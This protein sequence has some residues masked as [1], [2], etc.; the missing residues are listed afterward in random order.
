MRKYL[1]LIM[2]LISV[3]TI[4]S[5]LVQLIM[6]DFVLKIVGAAINETTSHFFSI[7][8]MFMVLFGGLMLHTI[9]S[10]V[11][12][13]VAVQWSALQKLGAFLAVGI[14]ITKGIFSMAAAPV[15]LFDLFSGLLFFYYNYYMKRSDENT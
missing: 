5:G 1:N 15:A 3:A 7:V 9:Y 12:N 11:H 10:P 8:G 4:G 6:P 14:G 2:I 13:P